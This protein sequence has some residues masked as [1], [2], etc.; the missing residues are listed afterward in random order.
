VTT[1]E[2]VQKFQEL[3]TEMKRSSSWGSVT[4]VFKEGDVLT[5]EKRVTYSVNG[6]SGKGLPHHNANKPQV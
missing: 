4:F 1:A 6:G 2:A 5:I 3:A